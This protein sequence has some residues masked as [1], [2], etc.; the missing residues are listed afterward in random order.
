MNDKFGVYDKLKRHGATM[1]IVTGVRVDLTR[2]IQ[3]G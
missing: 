1:A 2:D 3:F